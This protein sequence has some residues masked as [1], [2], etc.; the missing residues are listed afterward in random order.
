LDELALDSKV[1]QLDVQHE[2]VN[3]VAYKGGTMSL[4]WEICLAVRGGGTRECPSNGS[5]TEVS[6]GRSSEE[7]SVMEVERRAEFS[8]RVSY[9]LK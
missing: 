8:R 2:V 3:P 4:P 1:L 9:L 5:Q 6:R 7:A